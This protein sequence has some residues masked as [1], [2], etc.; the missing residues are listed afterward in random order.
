ML[1]HRTGAVPRPA[2]CFRHSRK[3][4]WLFSLVA[5]LLLAGTAGAQWI[6]QN[7]VTSFEKQADGVVFTMQT[8]ALRVAVSTDSIFHIT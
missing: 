2:K 8:G 4:A 3:A 6:P 5:L 1:N 7:P